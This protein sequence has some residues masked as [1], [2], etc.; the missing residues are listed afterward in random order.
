MIALCWKWGGGGWT[1]LKFVKC[2]WVINKKKFKKKLMIKTW[3]FFLGRLYLRKG[4]GET[5][6]CKIYDSPCLPEAEAMFAINADGIGDA[7]DWTCRVTFP[8]SP[9]ECVIQYTT[10]KTQP[11][12]CTGFIQ[13][14]A[15]LQDRSV[16][17]HG[18]LK[19][20]LELSCI[21]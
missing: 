7:K 9:T 17:R 19:H 18:E 16:Q 14:A 12:W 3:N 11:P 2:S 20:F 10:D 15:D 1:H 6:I 5:R 21:L 13:V 4:R 8:K